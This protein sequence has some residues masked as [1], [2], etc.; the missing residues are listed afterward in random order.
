MVG[1][2]LRAKFRRLTTRRLGGDRPQT[3]Q[4][5]SQIFSRSVYA[6][7]IAVVSDG[8]AANGHLVDDRR[9]VCIVRSVYCMFGVTRLKQNIVDIM[10]HTLLKRR[11]W[12]SNAQSTVYPAPVVMRPPLGVIL[13]DFRI[14]YTRSQ[15]IECW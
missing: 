5:N 1:T 13:S 9:T 8:R 10:Y 11:K 14:T 7:L 2:R 15:K 4:T 3:K 12:L 6:A